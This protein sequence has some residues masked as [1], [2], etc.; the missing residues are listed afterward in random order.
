MSQNPVP[1]P[2]G[3]T[4]IPQSEVL[5]RLK[6]CFEEIVPS[7]DARTAMNPLAFI[8][9]FVFCYL[10]DSPRFIEFAPC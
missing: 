1:I 7:E 2:Q 4:P 8:V 6:Q 9:S 3:N 5:E 10:G